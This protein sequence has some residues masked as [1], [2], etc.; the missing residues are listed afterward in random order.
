MQTSLMV[1]RRGLVV[2][3]GADHVLERDLG[4]L[5]IG[6]QIIYQAQPPGYRLSAAI[7]RHFCMQSTRATFLF[8]VGLIAINER[9]PRRH[10]Q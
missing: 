8:W 6:V 9:V 2:G 7:A 5:P 1:Y 10:H 4:G 3:L